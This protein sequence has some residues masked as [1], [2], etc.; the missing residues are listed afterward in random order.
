MSIITENPEKNPVEVTIAGDLT[1][2]TE[3]IFIY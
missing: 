2:H 1:I 3:I